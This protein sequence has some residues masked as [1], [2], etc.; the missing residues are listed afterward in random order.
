MCRRVQRKGARRKLPKNKNYTTKD[1]HIL[2]LSFLNF[3]DLLFDEIS[4]GECW[5]PRFRILKEWEIRKHH[6]SNRSHA[7]QQRSHLRRLK[8]QR[9]YTV[10]AVKPNIFKTNR[11]RE[12]RRLILKVLFVRSCWCSPPLEY[13]RSQDSRVPTACCTHTHTHTMC[14]YIGTW[15]YSYVTQTHHRTNNSVPCMH[16]CFFFSVH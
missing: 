8:N 2:F 4:D 1:F 6:C 14:L 16:A 15:E 11:H 12:W 13:V 9:E 3:L 10:N 5:W 7:Q